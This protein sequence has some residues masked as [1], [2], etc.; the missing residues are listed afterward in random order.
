[1]IRAWLVMKSKDAEPRSFPLEQGCTLV[2]RGQGVDL[3]ISL[4]QVESRHCRLILS[5]EGLLLDDLDTPDGTRWNGQIA[6][7]ATLSDGDLL[8]IG[9]VEFKIKMEQDST[10]QNVVTETKPYQKEKLASSVRKA[11]EGRDCVMK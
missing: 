5:D 2:G 8:K 3:R 4:P 9:P 11:P 6:S 1:M 10:R 7:E